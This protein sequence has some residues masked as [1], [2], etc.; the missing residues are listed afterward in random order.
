MHDTVLGEMHYIA[1]DL[2]MGAWVQAGLAR[3]E[4]YLDRWRLFIELYPADTP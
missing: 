4:R 3:L 1:D 2:D